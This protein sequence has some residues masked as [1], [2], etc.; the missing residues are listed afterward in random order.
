MP[1]VAA[2]K[3]AASLRQHGVA[4]VHGRDKNARIQAAD[5]QGDI[6]SAC[7]QIQHDARSSGPHAPGQYPPPVLVN[8]QTEQ[9]VEQIVPGDDAAEHVFYSSIVTGAEKPASGGHAPSCLFSRPMAVQ[10]TR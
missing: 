9:P 5:G 1:L 4:E 8:T 10:T 2:R 6:Q 3:L 7:G